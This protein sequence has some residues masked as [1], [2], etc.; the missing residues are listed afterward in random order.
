MDDC[1][2][3]VVNLL[4][5]SRLMRICAP[6]VRHSKLPFRALV[7]KYECDLAYTPMI[8]A[9]SFIESPKARDVEFTTN[10]D[11]RPLVV[12]F[13]ANNAKEFADAAELIAPLE[14]PG[15]SDF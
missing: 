10:S 8:I 7:R 2:G 13:A 9:K 5:E 1:Q 4:E 12:Q 14:L 15:I 6:M 11:D 3:N